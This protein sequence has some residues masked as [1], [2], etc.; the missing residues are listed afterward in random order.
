MS[1]TN[2]RLIK[3]LEMIKDL[4][5]YLRILVF[6]QYTRERVV[7]RGLIKFWLFRTKVVFDLVLESW[8]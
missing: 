4:M 7:K 2:S 3:I 6:T 5:G 8:G 1:S